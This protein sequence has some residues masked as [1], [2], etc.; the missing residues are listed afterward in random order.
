MSWNGTVRCS[1]CYKQGHNKSGCPQVAEDYEEYK[2]LIA[3][4]NAAHPDKPDIEIDQY[5]GYG[6]RQQLGLGYRHLRAKEI[7][8]TKKEKNTTRQCTYCGEV[9]HNRRTCA[10]L[11]STVDLLVKA[12]VIYHQKLAKAFELS[13]FHVGGLVQYRA[14]EYDYNKNEYVKENVMA[15]ITDL[16]LRSYSVMKWLTQDWQQHRSIRVQASNGQKYLIRPELPDNVK[17]ELFVGTSW[18]GNDGHT[19]LSSKDTPVPP[20]VF[21]EKEHRRYI[22]EYLKDLTHGRVTYSENRLKELMGGVS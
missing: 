9:G 14:E 2:N 20:H 12:S 13:G 18:R 11:K 5:M 8:E 17:N 6:I 19:I 1:I 4:Y 10:A 22:K 3:K 15:V 7:V 21:D 16:N